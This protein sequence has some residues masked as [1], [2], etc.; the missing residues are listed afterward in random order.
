[1]LEE[2]RRRE[3][4]PVPFPGDKDFAPIDFLLLLV[5]DP[6]LVQRLGFKRLVLRRFIVIL[7]VLATPSFPPRRPGGGTVGGL[8]VHRP[9]L[10]VRLRRAVIG[11]CRVMGEGEITTT[12]GATCPTAFPR[13][14]RGDSREAR[15]EVVE[16]CT[17]RT[18][19]GGLPSGAVQAAVMTYP[20]VLPELTH[21]NVSLREFIRLNGYLVKDLAA[22]VGKV[23]RQR[24]QRE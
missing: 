13:G 16:S 11:S 23:L 24:V 18:F 9:A 19:A 7:G 5:V 6:Q 21:P 22:D 14:A 8:P 1:Q 17:S 15:W 10:A 2:G 12:R 3:P 4:Q 20:P